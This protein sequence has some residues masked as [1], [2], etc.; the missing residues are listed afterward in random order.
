MKK[1]NMMKHKMGK[2]A[3][4]GISGIF[5]G[6]DNI[7][8][9]CRN[10]MNKKEAVIDIPDDR[11]II[12]YHSVFSSEYI[13]DT[14][15]SKR[16]GIIKNFKFDPHGFNIDKDLLMEIDPLHQMI[17]SAGREIMSESYHTKEIREKTGV[18]IAAISLPTE[19]SSDL[20]WQICMEKNPKP[21][22]KADALAAGVVSVPAAIFAR[23]FGLNGGCFT[24]DAACASSLFSIKLACDELLTHRCD[25]MIAGGASKADSLYTQIGFTQLKALS[26][27]GKCSPFD[28]NAD[29]LVVGE[30][31][32]LLALKRLED[33]IKC[34]DKIWGVICGTGLSNDIEGSLVSPA[35]E[36]QVRAMKA[37]FK[38]AGWLPGDVQLVEC[39]GSGTPVGDKIELNSMKTLWKEAGCLDKKCSIG[40]VKSMTGHLLTGAGAAGMIKTLLGM[41]KKILP[42]SINFSSA[43]ENSPLNTTSFTVQTDP[44][45]WKPGTSCSR[46]ISCARRAG[47]SA[48]GFGGINAHILVEEFK[49]DKCKKYFKSD[50]DKT[51]GSILTSD[52]KDRSGDIP[53][54]IVGMETI[55]GSAG[56]LNDFKRLIFGTKRKPAQKLGKTDKAKFQ[57]SIHKEI[58]GY[59]IREISSFAGEFHIP[60]NGIDDL[61]PQHLIMLKA[62]KKAIED[63]G[64][65]L[66]PENN[67][68]E[69]TKFGAAI[70][71]EFD[72][73]ACDFHLRWR[74]ALLNGPDAEN[75]MAKNSISPPL[76]P[77]RTL[78]A[79]GGIVASRIAREFQLGGP[80]FTVS[81]GNSSGIKAVDAGIKSLRSGETDIFLCGCVDM[82]GDVREILYN[83][84]L[85]P[86]AEKPFQKSTEKSSAENNEDLSFSTAFDKESRGPVPGEGAA[87]LI[88]KTLDR[89]KKDGNKIYGIIRGTGH[90]SGAVMACESD[91][92][93]KSSKKKPCSLEKVY[94]LSLGR[95]LDESGIKFDSIGLYQAHGSGNKTEDRIEAKVLNR[96]FKEKPENYL[97]CAIG[98]TTFAAGDT[99]AVSGLLSLITACLALHHKIIP[100]LHGF[101][102]PEYDKWKENNFYFPKFPCFFVKNRA[103]DKRYACAA[104]IT[105]DGAC[106]HAV[107]EEYVPENNCQDS[108]ETNT[109]KTSKDKNRKRTRKT[110]ETKETRETGKKRD[111]TG[112]QSHFPLNIMNNG[113]FIVEGDSEND[114]LERLDAFRRFILEKSEQNKN[115]NTHETAG[116]WFNLNKPDNT[117]KLCVSIVA[118]NINHII[119]IFIPE[120]VDAVKNKKQETIS[121]G[122]R[123]GVYYT[124]QPAGRAGKTAFLYPGSGNHFPGMGRQTGVLFPEILQSMENQGVSLKKCLLPKIYYPMRISWKKGWQKD[125]FDR[126]KAHSHNM[127]FGQVLF[128]TIMTKVAEKFKIKPDAAI[129]HSLGE[130]AS[131][132]ALKV[133]DNPEEMLLRMEKSDLFTKKLAGDFTEAAKLWKLPSK[134][135]PKWSVAAVNRSRKEIESAI[136]KFDRLYILIVNTLN[137]TI[138]G[139]DLNQLNTFIKDTGCGALFLDGVVSV[140][141]EVAKSVKN[142]YLDLH[143]FACNPP[144]N[145]DFYSCSL[146]KK[147]IPETDT[148]AESILNQALYGFDYQ[149][150]INTAWEDGIRVFVEMGPGSSCTRLVNKIL[151]KK[152]HAAFSFSLQDENEELSIIKAL[153]LLAC[154]R[155]KCDISPL[156]P[157]IKKNM[158]KDLQNKKFHT[159][160]KE[161]QRT[162]CAYSFSGTND[163]TDNNIHVNFNIHTEP[164]PHIEPKTHTDTIDRSLEPVV[165]KPKTYIEPKT[166]TDPNLHTDSNIHTDPN[167]Q[168]DLN[169]HTE[170]NIPT[171][172]GIEADNNPVKDGFFN[173]TDGIQRSAEA[174]AHAHEKFLNFTNENMKA[175]EKQ[176]QAL[177]ETAAN[178]I[179]TGGY[180]HFQNQNSHPSSAQ[181][182]GK[183]PLFT[184]KM[185]M[186]FATGSAGAVLGEKFEII[187]TYPVRVR[188]PDEPLMLVDRIMDIKGEMLSLKS[189]TI[190]TQ[191]DVKKNAWYLDGG[192]APV[193][194]T[195]E[196]GQADLF[197]CSWLGIDHAVKGKRRYR[198]LD[199]KVTFHRPLPVPGETIEY[200]ITIDRFLKQGGIYLFFFHYKG[201]INEELLISMRDGCAG[202]FTEKEI[203]NSIGIVHKKSHHSRRDNT[204][205]AG[206]AGNAA[207]AGNAGVAGVAGVA[208]DAGDDGDEA[209]HENH[210]NYENYENYESHANRGNKGNNGNNGNRRNQEK[211]CDIFNCGIS[212]SMFQP[213]VPV[214]KESYDDILI[215]A[216]RKGDAEKCFGTAFKNIIIGKNLRLP[217]ERMHLIDRV[218]EFDPYGG[219]FKS[220]FITAEADI[221]PDAWFLTC[222]FIDD[223][224]MPGTLMYECC[225]HTLRIFTQRMGW[226]SRRDEVYYDIIPGIESDL[227]CRGPVTPQTKKAQYQIEIKKMGY[228]GR[229]EPF[230]IA[231][232]HMFADNHQIV[233]YKNMGMKVVGL[234][235]EELEYLWEITEIRK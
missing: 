182:S 3:V 26:P 98:S 78:G 8:Q 223:K 21:L 115:L 135:K 145:I 228:N 29:G 80:C 17:L 85:R 140:H 161:K 193:S 106:S 31:V 123:H 84:V 139:G 47:V 230:V 9:F 209:D 225:A 178:F 15:C 202:F 33:A 163:D 234:L 54:A 132:F 109:N 127:I 66:R 83:H 159:G 45:E 147:Y 121:Q 155:V 53:I 191:H 95:A 10:I 166:H 1:M 194:I 114:L 124:P 49:P 213:L 154:H 67:Q 48:F 185:C 216:L 122:M 40:S 198:L 107:L 93:W 190:V 220:G 100:P 14:V 63:A 181:I 25:M 180:A 111:K 41:D 143:R 94:S 174:T 129:G 112:I 144:E 146:G 7:E 102:F 6:A 131:L 179:K 175:F 68:P 164:K 30:G 130:T 212:D 160:T 57:D 90:S 184:K 125:A 24:L 196:A 162:D 105:A 96:D 28:R 219:R 71:I 89:A 60:P 42:P 75:E 235:P 141:C 70:G 81:S 12:P 206:D 101:N 113:L 32:G 64:I 232:A 61:L 97:P 171:E 52:N 217:G 43:P 87:A 23:A 79:L 201:Y 128:G 51:S 27:S 151:G 183:L 172:S 2:I 204:G 82:S 170:S 152:A 215:E 99:K 50:F 197:L 19:K 18:I 153:A 210:E 36:G 156:F 72:H 226:I 169:L 158:D 103:E 92:S 199:A 148:T 231:D 222:H 116:L 133:W 189:G 13:P 104:S 118:D 4:T 149:S 192:R 200:R 142:E 46:D 20:A 117:K 176:F 76:T 55:T 88:L 165:L 173:F 138:I 22:T 214:K 11:W 37:A 56:N 69:R 205:D 177:A 58:H 207:D 186:E 167:I 137:E 38:N 126:I 59:W 65:P 34:G 35:G 86:F 233:F 188:L 218:I 224:V 5:P 73:K 44:E 187:D 91:F 195:I 168:P 110:R 150:L 136:E 108:D 227:K 208:T 134:V 120:A 229:K 203:K 62:A 77:G 16:A 119:D 221:K 157:L 211:F 74:S 39:H